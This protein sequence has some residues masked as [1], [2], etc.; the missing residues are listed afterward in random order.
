MGR[1]TSPYRRWGAVLAAVSAALAVLAVVVAL[2]VSRPETTGR[3]SPPGPAV[4]LPAPPVVLDPAATGAPL[5]EADQV[6]AAVHRLLKDPALGDR[7]SAEV[8]DLATGS[9]LYRHRADSPTIPASTVKLVTAATVLTARNP[10]DR[11]ATTAVAGAEP[12]EV[13]LVG[14]GDPTLAIDATGAYPGAARLDELAA[15]VR[16]S[17][18]DREITK[19]TVDSTVFTGPVHGQWDADI[20]GGGYVGPITGLMT[21]AGRVDPER[22]KMPAKRWEEP[23]LAAGR[24]FAELL[25]VAPDTVRRGEAPGGRAATATAAPAANPDAASPTADHG[26]V[27]PGGPVP[28]GTPLGRVYSPPI[29]RLVEIMLLDSDNVVA[30]ALARQVAMARGEP[31]SFAGGAAAMAK[32]LADLGLPTTGLRLADGS[33]LSR[34]NKVPASLLTALLRLAA[35]PERPELAGIFPGLP[36]AAWSGTLAQ[37]FEDDDSADGAGVVRAKTGTLLGV[38][39]IAGTVTTLEGRVLGFAFLADEVPGGQERARELLDAAASALAGCGC[40]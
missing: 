28:P 25:G 12:G 6:R 5:P 17:L 24:A 16:D 23:D 7:V 40:A 10:A 37:R 27:T 3:W 36:V 30:E 33:G 11:I 21:D 29:Q 35:S 13:V 14:G 26:A 19:V 4:S 15:Q 39:A 8:V 18:G 32:V 31:A 20:P 1:L 2:A 9:S 22:V 34:E 38:H